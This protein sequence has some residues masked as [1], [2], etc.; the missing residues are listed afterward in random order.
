MGN[1]HCELMARHMNGNL[2]IDNR[3]SNGTMVNVWVWTQW[4]V[5]ICDSG[6]DYP[7]TEEYSI[8]SS[9]GYGI[10]RSTHL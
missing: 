5:R 3:E 7:I 2:A 8:N 9:I 4:I 1:I 10:M 6:M